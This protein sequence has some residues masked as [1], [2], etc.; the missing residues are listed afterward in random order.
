MTLI[1]LIYFAALF[2]FIYLIGYAIMILFSVSGWIAYPIAIIIALCA[3]ALLYC[4]LLTRKGGFRCPPSTLRAMKRDDMNG[5]DCLTAVVSALTPVLSQHG[6]ILESTKASAAGFCAVFSTDDRLI[7]VSKDDRENW[8]DCSVFLA[9][10]GG[11]D[12]T[13]RIAGAI[14]SGDEVALSGLARMK[15]VPVEDDWFDVGITPSAARVSLAI[16]GLT[17]LLN[18]VPEVF[19]TDIRP[20]RALFDSA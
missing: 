7:L 9:P 6:F 14:E 1:E 10:N 19:D 13:V 3:S 18:S 17:H 8:L 16:R 11:N 15:G 5:H 12:E 4:C 20:L 2:A